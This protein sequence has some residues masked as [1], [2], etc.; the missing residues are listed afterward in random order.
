MGSLVAVEEVRAPRGWLGLAFFGV[1]VYL[2]SQ[3]FRQYPFQVAGWANVDAADLGRFLAMTAGLGSILFFSGLVAALWRANLAAGLAPAGVRGLALGAA[4]VGVLLLF[5]IALL[6]DFLRVQ[7]P[8]IG[9]LLN[10][11]EIG[12]IVGNAL[13]FAGLASL[14]VGLADAVGLFRK[15]EQPAEAL[16]PTQEG[17]G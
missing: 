3:I 5:E 12:D 1:F 13:A 4:G 14:G 17:T 6:F 15:A 2:V 16:P 7:L 10:A 8:A 11:H 9:S